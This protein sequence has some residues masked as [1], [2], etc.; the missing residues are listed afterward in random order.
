MLLVGFERVH[1]GC[2]VA[3]RG[4]GLHALA[5]DEFLGR[6]EVVRRSPV[7]LLRG[8]CHRITSVPQS[9]SCHPGPAPAGSLA[10]VICLA[11]LILVSAGYAG[12]AV[13]LTDC[14]VVSM[15]SISSSTKMSS[16]PPGAM[17]LNGDR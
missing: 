15:A 13:A 14:I 6:D 16:G 11:H 2:E 7:R 1:G 9:S 17:E 3:H 4:D 8:R 5:S 12:W 10:V